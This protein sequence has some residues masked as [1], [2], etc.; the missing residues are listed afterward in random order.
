VWN[1]YA[2]DAQGNLLHDVRLYDQD[3]APLTLGLAPD[4]N[5]KPVVDV[6]GRLVENVF[7]YRYVEADGTVANPDAGPAVDAPPLVGVPTA[8]ALPTPTASTAPTGKARKG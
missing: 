7:P 8:S 3:G 2:Y 1:I 4:V 5:R 6:K